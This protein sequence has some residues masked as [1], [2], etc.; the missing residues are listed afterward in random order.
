MLYVS[1]IHNFVVGCMVYVTDTDDNVEEIYSKE[2]L[3]SIVRGYSS[4]TIQGI[5]IDSVSRDIVDIRLCD[6]VSK[7][8]I[9]KLTVLY[10]LE[11]QVINGVVCYITANKSYNAD[12]RL[13]LSDYGSFCEDDLLS[14]FRPREGSLTLVLDD[15]INVSKG[16]FNPITSSRVKID[17]HEVTDESKLNTVYFS[18]LDNAG[19]QSVQEH[20]LDEADRKE[21]Y[22]GLYL[23]SPEFSHAYLSVD[24]IKL[25]R[26]VDTVSNI[27]GDHIYSG[28]RALVDKPFLDY[29]KAKSRFAMRHLEL[30]R[31]YRDSIEKGLH[32]IDVGLE[33]WYMFN[34]IL[35][36]CSEDVDEFDRLFRYIRFFK[37]TEACR[38][39]FSELVEKV[40][41]YVIE[42]E[43]RY[44]LHK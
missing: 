23:I 35:S 24:V 31:L 25:F 29:T 16:T 19:I 10:G 20:I 33:N 15:K 11:L 43:V 36:K 39:L 9:T 12:L 14:G 42:G 21:L 17:L 34:K 41:Y 32:S 38:D 1:A 8:K 30:F 7:A 27:I 28:F 44:A 3:Q 40:I 4:I 26:D 37:G 22:Y 6:E 5:V 13:R 18:L 2:E